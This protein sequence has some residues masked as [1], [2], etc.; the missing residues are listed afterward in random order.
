[1][2]KQLLPLPPSKGAKGQ[3]VPCSCQ[4][5]HCSNILIYFR[6]CFPHTVQERDKMFSFFK[7]VSLQTFVYLIS[8]DLSPKCLSKKVC[9]PGPYN[10]SNIFLCDTRQ[11]PRDGSS[12]GFRDYGA[13]SRNHLRGP[14]FE[15]FLLMKIILQLLFR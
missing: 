15:N 6:M 2:R 9:P 14:C 10:V 13:W 3:E 4:Y 11:K 7:L 5:F 12:G 1:M 8:I